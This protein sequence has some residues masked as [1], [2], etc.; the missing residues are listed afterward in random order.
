[1][2]NILLFGAAA[3]ALIAT[4]IFAQQDP[5]GFDRGADVTRADVENRVR[6]MFARTDAN[7]DGYITQSEAQAMRAGE[8]RADRGDRAERREAR[9][10]RR[11][12]VFAAL[13]RNRDGSIS[14]SEF[15]APRDR[16]GRGERRREWGGQRG[17]RRGNRGSGFGERAFELMDANKDGRVSLAEASAHR[18][19]AFLQ[20]D[21]NRDGRVTREERRSAREAGQGRRI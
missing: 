20:A 3:A 16:A 18:V 1:M 2:K 4:P 9:A 11:E 7:R 12:Q 15:L 10:D 21:S 5:G 13:D 6:A 14:R 19:R 8:R 17:E